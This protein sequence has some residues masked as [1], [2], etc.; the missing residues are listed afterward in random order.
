M[1]GIIAIKK[2]LIK[3]YF[4]EI[5]HASRVLVTKFASHQKIIS[6]PTK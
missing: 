5:N 4:K 3:M 2:N 1:Y 6:K